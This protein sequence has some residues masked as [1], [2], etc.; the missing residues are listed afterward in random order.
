MHT[1]LAGRSQ[2]AQLGNA[3]SSQL[4][5]KSDQ[6]NED[7]GRR[8]RVGQ[9][10]VT[11]SGRDPEKMNERGEAD[12]PHAAGEQ[13]ACEG[14]RTQRRLR[15][16]A[17]LSP[18]QLAL[19]ETLVEARIVRDEGRVAGE[20]RKP[21]DNR[22]DGRSAPQVPLLQPGQASHP[23]GEGNTRI[24]QRLK[25]VDELERTYP[26]RTQFADPAGLLRKARRLQVEDH[27]LGLLQQWIR[28]ACERDRR[29]RAHDPAVTG[30]HLAEERGG[31]PG[32]YRAAR[33]Q[34]PR[35]FHHG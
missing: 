29:R 18:A 26:D 15:Q 19:E 5:R 31:K 27:E 32:R 21:V 10:A 22:S 23:L 25:A 8:L 6:T 2:G 16:P 3:A 1:S 24:D 20:G 13:A 17:A 30:A 34:Q 4:L 11:G 14:C 9:R 35:R 12:P 7:L 28:C 33:E